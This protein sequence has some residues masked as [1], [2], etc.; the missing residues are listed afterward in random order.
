MH[1]Q[2]RVKIQSQ[3]KFF[4]TLV[5][6]G[7]NRF[8]R[9]HTLDRVDKNNSNFFLHIKALNKDSLSGRS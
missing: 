2:A 3:N 4:Q 8:K 9:E 7:V 5:K 6:R 1:V